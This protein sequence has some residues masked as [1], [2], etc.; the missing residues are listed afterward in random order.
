M[1]TTLTLDE[2]V[3]QRAKAAVARLH[4]PF[5]QVVNQALRAGLDGL[6]KPSAG[7]PY[8]TKPRGMG[9]R[10]GHNLDNIQE[11]LSRLEGEDAR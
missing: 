5:K 8:R 11:L 2:D 7:K 3:A 10:K 4:R 6:E 1:R 9:L